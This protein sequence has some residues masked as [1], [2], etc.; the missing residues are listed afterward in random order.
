MPQFV[1]IVADTPFETFINPASIQ[2]QRKPERIELKKFD[3]TTE[4]L[5]YG[6]LFFRFR[7]RKRDG[8]FVTR[9]TGNMVVLKTV[10]A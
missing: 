7:F 2:H 8:F 9:P 4:S 5:E 3:G 1:D 6:E 10:A